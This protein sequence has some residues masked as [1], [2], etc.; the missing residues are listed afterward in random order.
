MP[1]YDPNSPNSPQAFDPT[2]DNSFGQNLLAGIG[3]GLSGATMN[4]STLALRY[5]EVFLALGQPAWAL[6]PPHLRQAAEQELKNKQQL[7][8]QLLK[9]K[10]GRVGSVTG[11][12]VATAPLGALGSTLLKSTMLGR[13]LIPEALWA[14]FVGDNSQ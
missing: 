5:P 9:T 11:E 1:S 3:S 8:A 10:G 2:A 6:A 4:A 14:K 12:A 13:S 7:D